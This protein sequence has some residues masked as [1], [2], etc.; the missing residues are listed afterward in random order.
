MLNAQTAN[1]LSNS[2]EICTSVARYLLHYTYVVHV[3]I[4]IGLVASIICSQF[5]VYLM[6]RI[7]LSV[8]QLTAAIS[9]TQHPAQTITAAIK[10]FISYR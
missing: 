3:V 10:A 2:I 8:R 9:R 1:P 6:G 7:S 4:C 5:F